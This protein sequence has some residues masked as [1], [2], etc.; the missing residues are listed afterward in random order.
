M[1]IFLL[2]IVVAVLGAF[3]VLDNPVEEVATVVEDVVADLRGE[4]DRFEGISLRMIARH[5]DVSLV[6]GRDREGR[7][8][9]VLQED[10]V[11]CYDPTGD[12]YVV[13]R[14]F[15]TDFASIPGWAQFLIKPEGDHSQPA[16]IHDWL[17]AVGGPGNETEREHADQVF[18]FAMNTDMGVNPIKSAV[19]HQAVRFGGAASF[20]QDAE[21]RF[22]D[23]LTKESSSSP[24]PKPSPAA[25]ERVADC[26]SIRGR[27]GEIV[28]TYGTERPPT[29]PPDRIFR[30]PADVDLR[31]RDERMGERLPVLTTN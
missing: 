3:V 27:I 1:R 2:L 31:L 13:P 18:H 4:D 25:V 22:A 7:K 30:I 23:P 12:V 15:E 10:W 20:G 14:G 21:W 8:V 9:Y 19:M 28:M 11:Y 17:Y 5:I 26:E 6:P 16:V 24:I 29:S